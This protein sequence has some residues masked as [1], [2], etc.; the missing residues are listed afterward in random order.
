MSVKQIKK[1]RKTSMFDVIR[2]IHGGPWRKLYR[3][4]SRPIASPFYIKSSGGGH[5]AC[6]VLESKVELTIS[7]HPRDQKKCPLRRG[8]RL[9]EV[10]NVVFVCSWV[11]D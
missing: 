3:S 6:V 9:G 2:G 1:A 7:G 4:A 11:H 5:F 8:V 10:K